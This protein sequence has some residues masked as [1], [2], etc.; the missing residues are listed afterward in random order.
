[1]TK[2]WH[3]PTSRSSELSSFHSKALISCEVVFM[4]AKANMACVHRNGSM[5]E[6][7]NLVLFGLYWAQFVM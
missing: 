5:S 1:M 6:G 7:L 3:L 4:A 2:I